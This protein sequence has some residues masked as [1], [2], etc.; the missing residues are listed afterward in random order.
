MVDTRNKKLLVLHTMFIN[1]S[2]CYSVTW[3]CHT[4][5]TRR[6]FLNTRLG[7]Q[8]FVNSDL[9]GVLESLHLVIILY[10]FVLSTKTQNGWCFLQFH[11]QEHQEMWKGVLQKQEKTNEAYEEQEDEHGDEIEEDFTLFNITYKDM[12]VKVVC[13]AQKMEC[14]VHWFDKCPHTQ[15]WEKCG[16]KIQRIWYWRRYN[17]VCGTVPTRLLWGHIQLQLLNSLNC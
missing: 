15:H 11:Q 6:S 17:I 14:M 10:V 2:I 12:L 4:S 7:Y 1:K 3:R 9:S 13:D 5:Q 8:S 16:I